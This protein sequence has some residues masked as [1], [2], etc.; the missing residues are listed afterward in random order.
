MVRNGPNQPGVRKKPIAVKKAVKG[1]INSDCIICNRSNIPNPC[2][3]DKE[4][5]PIGSIP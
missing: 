3:K 5:P 1:I 4:N 2:S